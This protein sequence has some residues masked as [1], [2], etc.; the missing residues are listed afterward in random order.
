MT[1]RVYNA[2]ILG[3]NIQV[4]YIKGR[5]WIVWADVLTLLQY[6]HNKSPYKHMYSKGSGVNIPT[7]AKYTWLIAYVRDQTVTFDKFGKA[8]TKSERSFVDFSMLTCICDRIGKNINKHFVKTR[9]VRANELFKEVNE[10]HCRLKDPKY[11]RRNEIQSVV[12]LRNGESVSAPKRACFA[13]RGSKHNNTFLPVPTIP[14]YIHY[15]PNTFLNLVLSNISWITDAYSVHVEQG[16][17]VSRLKYSNGILST[18]LKNVSKS[19]SNMVEENSAI[20][21]IVSD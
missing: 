3:L 12:T 21:Q 1:H 4:L 18:R 6:K 20:I 14:G 10:L 5:Y 11:Q 16:M 7:L 8:R 15:M 19:M 17:L 2:N 9:V 13:R